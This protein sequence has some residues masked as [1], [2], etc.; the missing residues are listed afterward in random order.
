MQFHIF[1]TVYPVDKARLLNRMESGVKVKRQPWQA[2]LSRISRRLVT[3]RS[4]KFLRIELLFS[5]TFPNKSTVNAVEIIHKVGAVVCR[6]VDMKA[7][8]NEFDPTSGSAILA[9]LKGDSQR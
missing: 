9:T 4:G 3:C 6:S 1:P 5:N 8:K 2:A 7:C